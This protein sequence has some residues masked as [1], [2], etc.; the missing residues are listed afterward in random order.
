MAEPPG[1]MNS[2]WDVMN[3]YHIIEFEQRIQNKILRALGVGEDTSLAE[4]VATKTEEALPPALAPPPSASTEMAIVEEPPRTI[5]V[6]GFYKVTGPTELTFYATTTW[7]GFTVGTGWNIVGV[8]GV[9]GNLRVSTPSTPEAGATSTTSLTNEPYNWK[10]SFQS[11]TNQ[12]IE[13]ATHV[14]GAFLYP[15]GQEQFP[16]QQ[17]SG[18]I[19][20]YYTI[21]KNVPMFYF[22]SPPPDGTTVGWYIVGL[23]TLG[24]SQISEFNSNILVSSVGQDVVMM[25]RAVLKPLDGKPPPDTPGKVY[26]RGGAAQAVEPKFV[27]TFTPGTFSTPN[28]ESRPPVEINPLVKGGKRTKYMRDLDTDLDTSPSPNPGIIEVKNRGLST[29]SV[30]SLH[31]IGPQDEFM[32]NQDYTKSTWNPSFKQHTNF[33]MYQRVIPF[34]PANPSYQ[35]QTIQLE[36]LPTTLGHLLSNMYFK[37]TIPRQGTGYVINENIGRAIIKQV[38]LLVNETV[39]ETLYDDW[40]ILRDQVFL[41]ADEQKAMF[42]IV[43][44]LNSNVSAATA[45]TNIDVVCPLEFFFCRRHSHANQ[46][47]ERLRKPYFPLCAMWNQKLYVRFTFH[48][49]YWWSNATSNFDITNPK[50]IT[51]EILLDNSEKLYYQ[52]TQLRYI[53]PKV[54]KESTLEFSGGNPQLQLTANFPV[55]SLFWFFRNKNYESVRDSTGAPSALYYDTRYNYGYTSDYIQTGVSLAFQSSNNITNNYIDVIDNAK[56]TLNNVDILSTFQGSLYY[57]FKQP[58]EHALSAPSRNIYMYSFGLT[59]KEYN[60]GGFLDFS[61]LNS[62][63]STLTLNFNPT[64][65]SQIT[66]GY[67]LYL[68]YY[69]YTVL[70]FRD[71]FARLPFA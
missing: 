24:A 57:S 30:L 26:V 23:P 43:G 70:D 27:K 28:L 50:L 10:F 65:T 6:S 3:K 62:Q 25:P 39:I 47:R 32:S 63:T 29:G 42:N 14:M 67:N 17:R 1:F 13:G 36:L 18:A 40:Y 2:I 7:P 68:F 5:S 51:E 60:Q 59:P 54:K 9:I 44:G 45:G 31:A 16:S 66:Q 33:V 56:I 69:G 64:Y 48:P 37:C 38:D 8:P 46:D 41:D 19:Y 35:G 71:G 12:Y 4:A 15:P 61:K 34:P 58:L 21:Y 22:T 52:N 49:S 53:V 11:D 55:Q 20:G